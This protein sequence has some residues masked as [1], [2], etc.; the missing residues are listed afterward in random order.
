MISSLRPVRNWLRPLLW[1]VSGFLLL[2]LRAPAGGHRLDPNITVR[3]FVQA[4]TFDTSFATKVEVGTPPREVIIEKI[5]SI[6]ERDI[7]SFYPFQ[8][9]DG[10]YAVAFQLD[11]HGQII[12]ETLSSSKRGSLLIAAIN[13]RVIS[14]LL[15]D[16]AITDG[17]IYVPSGFT[18]PELRALGSSFLITGRDRIGPNKKPKSPEDTNPLAPR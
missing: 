17:I 12:L 8:A 5:P 1:G 2:P 14:P 9:P 10:T 4:T 11:R 6:S 13:G 15:I 18:Q 3:F 16:K 7:A